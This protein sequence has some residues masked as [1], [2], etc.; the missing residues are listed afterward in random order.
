MALIVRTIKMRMSTL[1]T[2]IMRMAMARVM[3][4]IGMWVR[5]AC[6]SGKYGVGEV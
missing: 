3:M 6:V 5:I 1:T 4:R 2:A